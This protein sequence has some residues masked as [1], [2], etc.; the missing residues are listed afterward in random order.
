VKQADKAREKR[1]AQ[2]Q[3][4]DDGDER[5]GASSENNE[6]AR[7]SNQIR[8]RKENEPVKGMN[9]LNRSLRQ[10]YKYCCLLLLR[11]PALI[12]SFG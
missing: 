10:S 3:H 2:A 8:G 12:Y 4:V 6:S 11:T 9:I 1:K 7:H 5:G